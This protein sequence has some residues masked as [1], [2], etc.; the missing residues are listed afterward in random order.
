M[1]WS[2]ECYVYISDDKGTVW[3]NQ[4][5]DEEYEEDLLWISD[6]SQY[7]FSFYLRSRKLNAILIQIPTQNLS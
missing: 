5:V 6:I 3:I 2:D 4:G 1:I 7:F